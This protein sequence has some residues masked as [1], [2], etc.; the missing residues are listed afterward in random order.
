M[1]PSQPGFTY[2]LSTTVQSGFIDL[3][4]GVATTGPVF[5]D[6]AGGTAPDDGKTWD[7]TN[8]NWNNGSGTATYA[9]GDAVTF[10]DTNN[11]NYSVTLS[12]TVSPASI[13]VNN[14]SG[15]YSITGTGKIADAGAFTKSG[16]G[17][18]TLG[19]A[20]TASSLSITAGTM[21]LA[22]N[23][24]LGSGSATSNVNISSMTITGTGQ[25]DI[26]NN[27]IIIDY[28]ST[29]PMST[30]YSYLK[31]GYNNGG[32]NGA[33][34]ISSTARTA[35]NNLQVRHRFLRWQRQNQ[36]PLHRHRFVVWP[37]RIEVHPARRCESRR[38]GQRQRLQHPRRELR[39]GLFELGSGK[40]PVHPG[41]QRHRLQR[42]GRQLRPGRQRRGGQ[43]LS[44]GCC[45]ARRLRRGQRITGADDC[46]IPEPATIGLL[47]I[48]AI[49]VLSRR[50]RRSNA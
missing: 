3:V 11:G 18:L 38:H 29:D 44:G 40:L 46:A 10:N 4:V 47:T 13:T 37:D 20:L 14:S 1:L 34:I 2:S 39:S 12:T 6:N 23:T 30:I 16:T 28:G 7:T 19:T 24:T 22:T 45:R 15:N 41:R 5:W 35:T 21:A 50:R 25:L 33:G 48:G 42:F 9:N 49:G 26:T 43:R 27:H 32:W 36:R 8:H 31:T 17:S